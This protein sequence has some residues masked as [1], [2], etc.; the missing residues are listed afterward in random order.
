MTPKHQAAIDGIL[1]AAHRRTTELVTAT[2]YPLGTQPPVQTLEALRASPLGTHLAALTNYAEGYDYP[3]R[4]DVRESANQVARYLFG[5]LNSKSIRFP[6][7][8]HRT[9]AGALINDALARFFT[10]THPGHLL[11]TADVCERF[12]VRRQTVH[13]WVEDGLLFAI[14]IDGTARFYQKDIERL[15]QSREH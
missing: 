10:E 14:Y 13:S 12:K 11:P 6:P 2:A 3:Y 7:K 9:P 1:Q 8:F 5:D 15:A 4:G